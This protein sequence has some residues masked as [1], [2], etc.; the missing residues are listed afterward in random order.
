MVTVENTY[1][2]A[3]G[4]PDAAVNLPVYAEN[5]KGDAGWP[6][7][8]TSKFSQTIVEASINVEF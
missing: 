8:F 6:T 3:L 4:D 5:V 2:T 1:N 7:E